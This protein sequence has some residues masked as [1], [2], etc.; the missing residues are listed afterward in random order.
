MRL[1]E[2]NIQ[3]IKNTVCTWNRIKKSVEGEWISLIATMRWRRQSRI[4]RYP[5]FDS[6]ALKKGHR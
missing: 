3:G 2:G 1:R 5:E 4:Y 6:V